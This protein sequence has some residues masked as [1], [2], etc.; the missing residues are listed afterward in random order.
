MMD[1]TIHAESFDL[2]TTYC[3]VIKGTMNSILNCGLMVSEVTKTET[4]P[5]FNT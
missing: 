2:E 1:F 5:H 3:L 4:V